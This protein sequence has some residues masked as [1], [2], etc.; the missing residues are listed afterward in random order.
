MDFKEFL[1]ER[2]DSIKDD[3]N[4]K[5]FHVWCKNLTLEQLIYIADTFGK[6]NFLDGE[7][8]QTKVAKEN[9]SKLFDLK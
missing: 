8:K 2:Y 7:I 9:L 6:I 4:E 5:D 3:I 1:K